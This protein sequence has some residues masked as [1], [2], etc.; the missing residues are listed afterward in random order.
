MTRAPAAP[1]AVAELRFLKRLPLTIYRPIRAAY[2]TPATVAEDAMIARM[3]KL[4]VVDQVPAAF[5]C[6]MGTFA[7]VRL[8]ALGA[9]TLRRLECGGR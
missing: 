5:E 2:L 8:T 9:M 6:R 7:C 4:G 3:I 1:D